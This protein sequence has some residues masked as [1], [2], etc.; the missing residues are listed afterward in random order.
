MR[1]D[2]TI[3]IQ[4]QKF[5]PL[6]PAVFHILMA[7]SRG[8]KHGYGIIVDIRRQTEGEIRMG[9]GTLYTAVKRLLGQDLVEQSQEADEKGEDRT[10]YSLS[11]LGEAVLRA[12]ARRLHRAVELA[13]RNSV[14]ES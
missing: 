11:P 7:L 14:L 12:E 3:G 9:T 5:L 1:R 4:A 13:E 6:T 10:L 8:R 2:T